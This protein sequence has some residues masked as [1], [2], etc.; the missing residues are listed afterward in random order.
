MIEIFYFLQ[1]GRRRVSAGSIRKAGVV[2]VVGFGG[3]KPCAWHRAEEATYM[4]KMLVGVRRPCY[5]VIG[6]M[7]KLDF[8]RA[9]S[10]DFYF[11]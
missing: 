4:W 11:I 10:M 1:V 2:K 9:R 5:S 6:S 7:Y 8:N 3:A